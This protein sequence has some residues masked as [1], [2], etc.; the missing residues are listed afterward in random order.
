MVI[1]ACR[2]DLF[3]HKLKIRF[4][5]MFR[6]KPEPLILFNLVRNASLTMD[7]DSHWRKATAAAAAAISF[8]KLS[9]QLF[10]R[11]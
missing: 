2:I 1:L 5:S 9:M 8:H 7:L 4:D 6:N 11:Y 10:V 3:D